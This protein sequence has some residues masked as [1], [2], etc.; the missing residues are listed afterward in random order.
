MN[1]PCSE[2]GANCNPD[3]NPENEVPSHR[4]ENC[5]VRKEL[6][7]EEDVK[8]ESVCETGLDPDVGLEPG[9][10]S[11]IADRINEAMRKHG[12]R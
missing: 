12:R 8:P 1:L 3:R 9:I 6:M 7:T 2:C 11:E 5:L 4:T 10:G